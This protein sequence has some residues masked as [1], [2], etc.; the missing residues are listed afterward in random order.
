MIIRGCSAPSIAASPHQ[1]VWKTG[2]ITPH[3]PTPRKIRWPDLEIE[4]ILSWADAHFARTGE[5][6][7][8]DSGAVVDAGREK[9]ANIDAALRLG[10]RSL[11]RGSSLARLL[12]HHRGVRNRKDLPA[13]TVEEIL[14][15]A[16]AHHRRKG[17][18][19]Q[20]RS[21][22]IPEA[23]GET[24]MAVEMALAHGQRGMPGGTSLARLIAEQRQ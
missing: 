23:P 10:M 6:P 16:D 22:A 3:F 4:Q 5:W 12:Q 24:W 9:W 13:L 15:W 14:C 19:P 17:Q 8:A 18:W 2:M 21:G 7:T 20:S 11:E 1:S